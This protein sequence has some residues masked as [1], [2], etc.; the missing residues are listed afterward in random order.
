MVQESP[1]ARVHLLAGLIPQARLKSYPDAADGFLFQ[2]PRRVSQQTSMP[3]GP[4][5]EQDS[6]L[7][8]A[9]QNARQTRDPREQSFLPDTRRE[10]TAGSH[11]CHHTNVG[12]ATRRTDAPAPRQ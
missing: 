11:A 8:H 9:D 5:P 4:A 12:L 1:F 7:T 10:E 2:A 3:S 6:A